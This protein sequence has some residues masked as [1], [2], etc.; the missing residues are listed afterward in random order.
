MM[1]KF[2]FTFSTKIF[3]VGMTTQK[4]INSVSFCVEVF[5]AFSTVVESSA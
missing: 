3:V 2:R 4:T 1:E 5:S